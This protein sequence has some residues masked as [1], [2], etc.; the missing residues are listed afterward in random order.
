MRIWKFLNTD[1]KD[2]VSIGSIDA[3]ADVAEK[4]FSFAEKLNKDEIK[5]IAPIIAQGA[6][7]L[8]VLNS[9]IAELAESTLPFVKIATSLLKFY[10]E[11][12]KV[13]PTLAQSI[14]LVSQAAY[15]ESFRD[16]FRQMLA[17]VKPEAQARL[18]QA[19]EQSASE[20]VKQQIKQLGDRLEALELDDRAARRA[21]VFFHESPFAKVFN[22]ALSARLQQ[23]G[24][25]ATDASQ[26]AEQVAR[27]TD[28]FMLPALESAGGA[29]E[30]LVKWYQVGGQAALEKYASLDTYLQEQIQS[31]PNEF[32]F[33]EK[34]TFRD[35]YVPLQAQPL[36][37]NGEIDKDQPAIELEQWAKDLLTDPDQQNK[38]LFI[39]GGPGR[40]KSVFCR[41]FADWVRENLHPIWTPILIRLRDVRTIE[42]DFEETLRKAVNQDFAKSDPGWLNDRNIRY[43]F[44]LDGFDE[45]LM[46]GR[47]S[48]GLEEFLKQVGRF[49]ESCA[50]NSEKQHRVLI[51]GRSLSLQSIDRLMPSNL[52]R[53]EILPMDDDRQDQ[54]LA[55][56]GK[57]TNIKTA[58]LKGILR[59]ERL[60]S[61]VQE[62]TR[63]PLLLYLLAAMHRDGELNL[64]MFEGANEASAKVLIYEKSIDWVLNQQRPNWLQREI[65]EF[66]EGGLR[67]ILIEAGLCVVQA[68]GESALIATIKERLKDDSAAKTLIDQAEQRLGEDPLKNALASF[69]LES[70]KGK[71][72]SVEFVHK[73]F[74]EFLC[75]ERLKE[76]VE[77]WSKPGVRRSEPF[78][79][80]EEQMDWEIY[81]L[82]GYGGL[83]V[84]IVGYLMALLSNSTEF[85]PV[86]LFQRLESFYLRWCD[87]EFI[88]S[89]PSK[90]FPQQKM[91][92]LQ[93]L[94]LAIGL[95]QVDVFAG[96]NVMI[97]LLELN[98]YAKTREDLK[99]R[100]VFY[101]CGKPDNKS[102]SDDRIF[103]IMSY[104]CCVGSSAFSAIVGGF[105]SHARLNYAF[106]GSAFLHKAFLL[107]ADLTHADLTHA[108]LHE[109]F[110]PCANL[111]G[112]TLFNA[113]LSAACLDYAN[114]HS[115]DLHAAILC[116][117]SLKHT[118]LSNADLSRAN[119]KD[120]DLGNAN[121]S[122]ANFDC[123]GWNEKT[124][125]KG[126][127]GLE[128]A[129]NVPEALKKQLG[130]EGSEE[131]EE[132]E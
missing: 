108:F 85:E 74:S 44:L 20:A 127:Q 69:F 111:V 1:I 15:L 91:L 12:T 117:A 81:D 104:G 120:V 23:M 72:G 109:A 101:P 36:L 41:M 17:T 129:I 106:L 124:N 29:T 122:G 46:E 54:W 8:D 64:E 56:W 90:N 21:I 123:I 132:S 77:D 79:V 92:Q 98:R 9:P 3:A 49:Q 55:K 78:L 83:T 47:T 105:L 70:G 42:K 114:L 100:I 96:L 128:N 68:G 107:E 113:N 48:G 116:K 37:K 63:E 75:A 19:S 112:T 6:S 82:L 14:A 26:I 125:W 94:K 22:Q 43:L 32:V 5:A 2:L 25:P 88:D 60:P 45:L 130:L 58:Y 95:R 34:F 118:D 121:V 39:Q 131:V 51:T 24:F 31:K 99:E 13:E 110:L 62:L 53:V 10:L 80:P 18:K 126:V 30:R 28:R 84:E 50:V 35:I 27:N 16:R 89:T 66:E 40:G 52:E 103:R 93:G 86:R 73:S 33:S 67:R 7:L 38:V 119:L 102:F 71:D 59:D 76:A 115:A 4:T 57:L 61:S 11:K 97:L 87:G 65:T